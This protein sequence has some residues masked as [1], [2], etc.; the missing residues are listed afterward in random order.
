MIIEKISGNS[1]A[2]VMQRRVAQPLGL[3]E[4]TMEIDSDMAEPFAHGYLVGQGEP[5]D[6]TRI[7]GSAVFGNGNLVSTPLDVARFYRALV[8]GEVVS[9]E[10][11]PEM[12]RVDTRVTPKYAM[13]VY[14]F[15]DFYP[16]GT[17]IGH[18][19]QTPGYDNI[20]YSSLDG[21]KQFAISVGS[22]TLDDKAGDPAAQEAWKQ[23]AFA[24]ACR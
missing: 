15:N 22:S 7:S 10:Q 1:L 21:R 3:S 12:F 16:C 17:F 24:V 20:G 8:Q 18:D 14:R 9:A 4:T 11:L 6:V 2:D 13:G 23:L 5:L 19:G